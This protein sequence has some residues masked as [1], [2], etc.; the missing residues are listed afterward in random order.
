MANRTLQLGALGAV[1]GFG[2]LMGEYLTADDM[3]GP[4]FGGAL[5]A[6][7]VNTAADIGETMAV[8]LVGGAIAGLAGSLLTRRFV[9]KDD[10]DNLNKPGERG[11]VVVRV[12]LGSTAGGALAALAA[13]A[14]LP[15][16]L[17]KA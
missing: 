12:L 14:L 6:A 8:S 10:V 3:L 15:V 5:A 7:A 16:H 13:D 1:A 4:I 11:G 2:G 9:T 17:L